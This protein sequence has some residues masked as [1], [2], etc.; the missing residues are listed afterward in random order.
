MILFS[1]ELKL[2]DIIET[3][4]RSW[5]KYS[6][7]FQTVG[8]LNLIY[9]LNR[10]NYKDCNFHAIQLRHIFI[11]TFLPHLFARQYHH[12]FVCLL[13]WLLL[14]LILLK[15]NR[16]EEFIGCNSLYPKEPVFYL[17]THLFF[18]FLHLYQAQVSRQTITTTNKTPLIEAHVSIIRKKPN[19]ASLSPFLSFTLATAKQ[20]QKKK[21]RRNKEVFPDSC[22]RLLFTTN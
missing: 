19:C 10:N 2:K 14:V 5:H 16:K 6:F 18:L 13:N 20:Y 17:Y 8:V 3:K 7:S 15:K 11:M 1:F 4:L 12:D 22:D 9:F 21:K